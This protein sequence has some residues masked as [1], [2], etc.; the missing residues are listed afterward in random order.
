MIRIFLDQIYIIVL[1]I[2]RVLPKLKLVI[3]SQL[4]AFISEG[5]NMQKYN[6]LKKLCLVYFC[7][8][9]KTLRVFKNPILKKLRD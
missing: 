6:T 3:F 7:K 4:V 5:G 8:V 1:Q 9:N 2:Q